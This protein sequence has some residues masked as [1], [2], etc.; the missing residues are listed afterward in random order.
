MAKEADTRQKFPPGRRVGRPAGTGRQPPALVRSL[1]RGLK[2]L[3]HVAEDPAG[4]LLTDLASRVDLPSSTVHRLLHTLEYFGFVR[5]DNELG[6]WF[7]GVNAFQT[8]R[9]FL[10]SRDFV[11]QSRPYLRRLMEQTGETANLSVV[12]HGGV[13]LLAQVECREMMRMVV[14]PGSCS[15]LHASGV[16]KALLAAMD[17]DELAAVTGAGEMERFTGFTIVNPAELRR[18]LDEIRHR[19]WAYD[20][21][22]HAIGL[23][24]VAASIHDEQGRALA[25]ISVSGPMSRMP[26]KRIEELGSVVA[27]TAADIT[28]ALGGYRP[29]T[30]KTGKKREEKG[31]DDD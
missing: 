21:Q 27:A 8:G 13:V 1:A 19:G 28:A 14:P 4:I 24:C 16:G 7:I 22:E 26:D 30:G 3:H 12:D 23:R 5:Q 17:E 15:P 9:A 29:G 20:D 25:A 10:V 18:T 11:A 2:L 31:Q 6:L